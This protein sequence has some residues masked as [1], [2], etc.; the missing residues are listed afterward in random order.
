MNDNDLITVCSACVQA[1]CWQGNFM[2][3]DSKHAGILQVTRR[4]LK[5][6]CLEHPSYWKTDEELQDM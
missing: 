5:T 4:K 3:Q 1:S 2:C 6:L